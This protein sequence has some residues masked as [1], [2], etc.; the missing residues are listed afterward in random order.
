[1]L[2]ILLV[3][4]IGVLPGARA[5]AADVTPTGFLVRYELVIDGPAAKVYD[6]LLDVGSWWSDQHTYSGAS[7]NLSIDARGGGC[8]CEK[9]PTG[10]V[11]HMRVVYLKANEALRMS[12]ALG[13]LQAH[14]VAGAMTWRLSP[15]DRGT[16]LDLTYS[17]GGFMAGGFEKIAPAVETVLK[18][19][20]DRLKRYVE[21]GT[22]AAK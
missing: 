19:Q 9:L 17:V 2:R 6:S 12:G 4:A 10:A 1:M 13:P 7:R 3:S 16:K 15:A 18:E 8:F 14:G 21:T 20:A 11:E 5:W 22:P